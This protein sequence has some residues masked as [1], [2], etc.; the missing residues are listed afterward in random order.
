MGH[1]QGLE[2]EHGVV[3]QI[4]D[5]AAAEGRGPVR[6][7]IVWSNQRLKLGKPIAAVRVPH[8]A[9]RRVGR[10]I[11]PTPVGAWA[12]VKHGQMRQVVEA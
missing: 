10:Q 1:A 2:R 5:G 4:A 6:V 7:T 12:A 8:E 11:G 9:L 3:R